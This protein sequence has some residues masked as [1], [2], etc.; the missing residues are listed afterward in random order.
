MERAFRAF[1]G[2]LKHSI[3]PSGATY[4]PQRA[5]IIRQGIDKSEVHRSAFERKRTRHA[6]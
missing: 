4:A 2:L 5:A 6:R 3:W 1:D